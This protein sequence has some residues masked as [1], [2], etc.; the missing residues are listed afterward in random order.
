MASPLTG[1]S[2]DNSELESRTLEMANH[3]QDY[4]EEEDS[5]KIL[6]AGK[7]G[8]GKSSLINSIYG[9]ELAVEDNSA[10]A[11]TDEIINYTANV[12]TPSQ[13]D[14]GKE[15]TI[16]IWDSPGFG[17]VFAA[18]KDKVI[19]ELKYV[20]DKAHILVY[21]FDIRGRMTRDDVDG[22]VEI[23]K[24]VSHDIWINSVF[25]LNFCNDLRPPRKDMDAVQFFAKSFQSWHWQIIRV[26]REVAGVPDRI[27]NNVS[28]TACGYRE[29]QPPGFRNWYTT[30]WS[31][32]FE[33]MRSD[34]QPL[35]LK[36]TLDRCVN[37]SIPDLSESEP[38]SPKTA[39]RKTNPL[40]LKVHLF[41]EREHPGL[42]TGNPVPNGQHSSLAID[43][44]CLNASAPKQ[45]P[46]SVPQ[47]TVDDLAV[48]IDDL[49]RPG[50]FSGSAHGISP[51][52]QS[53]RPVVANPPAQP[54]VANPPAQRP[55]PGEHPQGGKSSMKK[56][57]KH[58]GGIAGAAATGV[59]VGAL[60]GIAGGP[61]GIGVGTVGGAVVGTTIGVI[62]LIAMKL[63]QHIKKKKEAV[64]QEN[65]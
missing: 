14:Q 15:S 11:V 57:L 13:H 22:I 54:V 1:L 33:K 31:T 34:G 5:L 61:I 3:L 44:A 41:G 12:P 38:Q 53:A 4:L 7:M 28:I 29:R 21:C 40:A 2:E 24:Q 35:L 56:F 30:F 43:G 26:L 19:E 8:V 36:L 27:V 46:S 63:G 49:L 58:A 32:I 10:A 23:T 18:D 25:T 47:S 60:V 17:D 64:L 6:V 59:L 42:I 48:E 39:R 52:A 51:A 55:P 65:A 45:N 16:T 9:A 62:A 37:N 20:V 50:S